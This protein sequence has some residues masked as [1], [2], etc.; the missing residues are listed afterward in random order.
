MKKGRNITDYFSGAGSSTDTKN[1]KVDNGVKIVD[2]DDNLVQF[3][4]SDMMTIE[5]PEPKEESYD[6][7]KYVSE[8][9]INGAMCDIVQSSNDGPWQSVLCQYSN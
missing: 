9:N 4:A 8:V 2:Y 1:Q 7:E 5:T 6:N 3:K